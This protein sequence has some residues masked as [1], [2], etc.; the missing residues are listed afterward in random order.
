MGKGIAMMYTGK[1][2][3]RHRNIVLVLLSAAFLLGGILGY[4]AQDNLPASSYI[5]LFLREAEPGLILWQE[6]WSVFRWPVGLLILGLFPL[7]G[8]T[9]PAVMCLRGFLL[10][11]NISAFVQEGLT[12][13]VLLFGPTCVFTLPVLFLLGTDILLRKAGERPEGKPAVVLACLLSLFLCIVIDLTVV[14]M[15]LA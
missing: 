10:S 9:I 1:G 13:A 8:I 7:V 6:L 12:A 11:Y 5:Q 3:S 15:L 2:E 4:L 14:P